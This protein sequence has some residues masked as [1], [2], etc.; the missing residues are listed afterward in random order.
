MT[1]PPGGPALPRAVQLSGGEPHPTRRPARLDRRGPP[2]GG[3]RRRGGWWRRRWG[4]GEGRADRRHVHRVPR[5]GTWRSR[6]DAR[7]G[8]PDAPQGVARPVGRRAPGATQPA[9]GG[10]AAQRRRHLREAHEGGGH[11]LPVAERPRP[12]RR[13]RA[14]HLG[15]ADRLAA[16]H[17]ARCRSARRAA[18][19]GER[20]RRLRRRGRRRPG[21]GDRVVRRPARPEPGPA[22][23]DERC[24]RCHS[25]RQAAHRSAGVRPSQGPEDVRREDLGHRPRVSSATLPASTG[26]RSPR[27]TSS[28]FPGRRRGT[29]SGFLAAHEGGHALQ[30]SSL[31]PAQITTLTTLYRPDSPP[32]AR[33]PR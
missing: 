16:G 5:A 28:P 25:A 10:S 29:G 21:L 32:A 22:P 4:A 19:P 8:P 12:G 18:G 14:A 13:R 11:L 33:S 3:R 24:A 6:R 7:E 1:R 26:S 23:D 9:R 31:T 2:A 15:V 17:P 27:R 30:A 20:Q